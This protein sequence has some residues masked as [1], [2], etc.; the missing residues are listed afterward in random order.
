MYFYALSCGC[1]YISDLSLHI[2]T[3]V[4]CKCAIC[5]DGGGRQ[6]IML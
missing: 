6:L 3:V 1:L 2:G 5:P 4:E